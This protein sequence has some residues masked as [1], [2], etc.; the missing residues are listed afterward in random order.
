MTQQIFRE[1]SL[2]R[3]NSPEKLDEYLKV[4]SPSV[5]MMLIGIIV[6]LLGVIVWCCVGSIKTYAN[7]SCIVENKVAACY[8]LQ[9][10]KDKVEKDMPLIIDK[11]TVNIFN[12]SSKGEI[13]TNDDYLRHML[14]IE[15]G[16][17]V[18]PAFANVDLQDGYYSGKIIVEEISPLK[19]II[20]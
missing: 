9:Q 17:Y 10:D 2:E 18:F 6:V 12:V 1:K 5:W 15:D 11:Q 4:T 7:T 20:N 3:V 19:F 14:G 13:I 8:I 16:E